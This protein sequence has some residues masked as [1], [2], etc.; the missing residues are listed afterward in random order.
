MNYLLVADIGNTNITIGIFS[1]KKIVSIW[2]ISSNLNQTV[3]E[4][5][6]KLSSLFESDGIEISEIHNVSLCSV[7]PNLTRILNAKKWR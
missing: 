7:V 6:L 1:N 3:D 4:F 5:S 2:R